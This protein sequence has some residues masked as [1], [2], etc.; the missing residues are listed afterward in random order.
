MLNRC[1]FK[2]NYLF[3]RDNFWKN[4][5]IFFAFFMHLARQFSQTIFECQINFSDGV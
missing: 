2:K 1:E 3:S 5:F 4:A